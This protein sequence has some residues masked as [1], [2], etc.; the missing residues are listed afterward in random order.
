MA[1]IGFVELNS[2]C[3]YFRLPKRRFFSIAKR[4]DHL[5]RSTGH[6]YRLVRRLHIGY[7]LRDHE[8]LNFLRAV[9]EAQVLFA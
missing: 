7:A 5:A 6:K 4:F 1:H 2:F 8:R 3:P 9:E